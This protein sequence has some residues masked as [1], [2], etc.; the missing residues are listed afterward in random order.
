MATAHTVSTA[1]LKRAIETRDGKALANFYNAD[2]VIHIIDRNNPPSKPLDIRGHT[3]I[4]AYWD[5]ICSRE[6]THSVEATIAD[7]ERLAFT[8]KCAYPVAPKWS[9]R[10]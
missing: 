10:R 2:A 8:E 5:N 3:A 1:D 7:G 9:A 6:M 4:A